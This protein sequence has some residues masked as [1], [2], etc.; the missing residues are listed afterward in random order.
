MYDK[1]KLWTARTRETPDVSK[2]LDRAKD[3]IDLKNR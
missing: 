2:F 1:V 3:Q